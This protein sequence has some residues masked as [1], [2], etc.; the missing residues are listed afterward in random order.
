MGTGDGFVVG[1]AVAAGDF[2]AYYPIQHQKVVATSQKCIV[3][4]WLKKQMATPHIPKVFHNAT[5]DLGWLKWAGVEV[6]GKIIDTMIAAPLL[7]E[8][9]FTYSLGFIGS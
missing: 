3:M 5:Y 6:Q 1:I 2:N 4:K 8:N 7:N 9:R